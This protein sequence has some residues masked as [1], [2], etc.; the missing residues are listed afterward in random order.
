MRKNERIMEQI[1]TLEATVK[2]LKEDV[3][4]K[5]EE[6]DKIINSSGSHLEEVLS[7]RNLSQEQKIRITILGREIRKLHETINKIENKIYNLN[8]KRITVSVKK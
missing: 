2:K 3:K 4:Q 6:M 8:Q 7:G 1:E 5:S